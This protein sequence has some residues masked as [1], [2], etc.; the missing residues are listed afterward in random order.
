[1]HGPINIR[2]ILIIKPTRCTN[3]SNLVLEQ[4]STCSDPAC[5]LSGY[6][7]LCVQ[8]K[9]PDDGQKNCPKHVEFYSKKKFEKLMHLV[10]FS[11]RIYQDARSPERQTNI[12][13]WSYLAQFFLERVMFQTKVVQKIKTRILCSTN[14][15]RKSCVLWDNVEKL[16]YSRT[17][18]RR[19][20]GACE[21]HV[22]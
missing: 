10:G 15:L 1:M 2:Q 19:Q 20:H 18:H 21:L 4:N 12:H 16:L 7:L 14:F 17:G 22:E 11:I 5:T 9:T 6:L 13:F 8:W 3:F